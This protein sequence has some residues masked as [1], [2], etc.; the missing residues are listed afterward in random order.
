MQRGLSGGGV[1]NDAG[2]RWGNF[3][4]DWKLVGEIYRIGIT[5]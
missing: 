5:K 2:M 4:S 3:G 1:G